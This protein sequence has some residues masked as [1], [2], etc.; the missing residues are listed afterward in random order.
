MK[1][2]IQLL[3]FGAVGGAGTI[4]N[5]LVFYLTADLAGFP[6]NL[7]AIA[8][9]SIAV[10][11]N[12]L[13][14]HLWTFHHEVKGEG[15]SFRRYLR[16][17]GVALGGFAVNLLVLNLILRSIPDLPYK[18]IAQGIGVLSGMVVNYIGSKYLV[19]KKVNDS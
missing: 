13:L 2:F 11:Q 18:T 4:I 16:F 8:A 5:L 7:S 19:F 14:N 1:L 15:F 3:R 6:V 17:V 9:F 12:Y 10:T